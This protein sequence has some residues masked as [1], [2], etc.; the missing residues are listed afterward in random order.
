MGKILPAVEFRSDTG[1]SIGTSLE[2]GA[3]RWDDLLEKSLVGEPEG[4]VRGKG[5]GSRGPAGVGTGKPTPS[6]S[7]AARQETGEHHALRRGFGF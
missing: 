3:P 5:R 6:S 7:V 1:G 4:T 2:E